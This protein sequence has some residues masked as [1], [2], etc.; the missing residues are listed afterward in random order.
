MTLPLTLPKNKKLALAFLGSLGAGTKQDRV[1][2][3][4]FVRLTWPIIEPG[5]EFVDGFHI[6]AICDYLEAV[7]AGKIKRLII[8][9]PPRYGKSN[10]ITVLW[11]CWEWTMF[12]SRRFGFCSYS[13]NLSTQHSLKRRRVIESEQYKRRWGHMVK[14][15]RDQNVKNEFE[16]TRRGLMFSTSTG[17]TATG[18]GGD[19]LIG[20]DVLNPVTAESKAERE[21]ALDFIDHVWMSRLDDKRFGR[22]VFVEQ[23]LH[24][25]DVT[26]HLTARGGWTVL[27]LPAQ[28]TE[29]REI[30]LPT[31]NVTV[32][33][34][35]SDLLAPQREGVAELAALQLQMGTRA[36]QAQYLQRPSA[37]EGALLRRGWFRSYNP[38]VPIRGELFRIWSWDTAVKEGEQN[39]YSVGTYW[40]LA[41][42]GF[43]LLKRVKGRMAYPALKR[44]VAEQFSAHPAQALL[45]EDASSG[46]LLIQDF[47]TMRLPVIPVKVDKDKTVRVN[48]VSPLVEAGMVF[49]PEA[50]DAPW[51]IDYRDN[52]CE[53]P[54]AEHDDDVDSTTQALTYMRAR[55]SGAPSSGYSKNEGS[56]WEHKKLRPDWA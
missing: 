1:S 43:F 17:G 15:E 52:L 21:T 5:R 2:L 35:Q 45:I 8:N 12:P 7:S 42:D 14:L 46:A 55:T 23:R 40:S 37:E 16:N 27:T 41:A 31:S 29:R 30:H 49:L 4:D 10:L 3:H 9:M 36:Y 18:K 24:A 48:M 38:G 56:P 20:D 33:K 34:E 28:F 6:E 47:K 54:Y 53:F 22:M 11:P 50:V 26:A 32:V 25:K 13:A 19:V 44:E 51:V 39:D